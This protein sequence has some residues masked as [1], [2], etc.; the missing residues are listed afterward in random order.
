VPLCDI[1]PASLVA[2]YYRKLLFCAICSPSSTIHLSV[3]ACG[4]RLEE[5]LTMIKSAVIFTKSQI[6]LHIFADSVLEV[7][8]KQEV[9]IIEV[10][11]S[12][13]IAVILQ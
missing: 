13:L 12:I 3:V 4:D 6:D 9:H 1:E 7:E 2:V 10:T 8:F 11:F 5:T